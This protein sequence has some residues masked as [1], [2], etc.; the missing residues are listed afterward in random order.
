MHQR[1]YR[2]AIPDSAHLPCL[3]LRSVAVGTSHAAATGA[4][5]RCLALRWMSQV[6]N[7]GVK[8]LLLW[9]IY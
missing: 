4:C 8:R 9:I 6:C 7:S 2:A 5:K 1:T 3:S